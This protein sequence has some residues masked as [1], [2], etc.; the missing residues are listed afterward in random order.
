[1]PDARC[2]TT[3]RC[4][5]PVAPFIHCIGLRQRTFNYHN[6]IDIRMLTTKHTYLYRGLGALGAGLVLIGIFL[7][8]AS[9]TAGKIGPFG[10]GT[11]PSG[12]DL[13]YKQQLSGSTLNIGGAIFA[14]VFGMVIFAVIALVAYG[15]GRDCTSFCYFLISSSVFFLI[16]M[17]ALLPFAQQ[18]IPVP[19]DPFTPEKQAELA[20]LNAT[21][22]AEGSKQYSQMMTLEAQ[23]ETV[24]QWKNLKMVPHAGFILSFS[25]SAL[26]YI[27][28]RLVNSDNIRLE[29]WRKYQAILSQ[30]HADGKVTTDEAAILAKERQLLKISQPDHEYIIRKTVAD[31]A[32]QQRLLAM[33][34]APIDVEQVLRRRE[35]DTYK[36]SLVQA[37]ADGKVTQDESD[38]LRT[39]REGLG[40]TEADHEAMMSE[41]IESGEIVLAGPAPRANEKAE[42]GTDSAGGPS[43][44]APPVPPSV[45]PPELSAIPPPEPASNAASVPGGTSLPSRPVLYAPPP[46]K[47]PAGDMASAPVSLLGTGLS[48]QPPPAPPAPAASKEPLKLVKCTKCGETIP[49]FTEE[50]PLE[51]VCPRCGFKGMLRK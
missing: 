17:L 13:A 49:V 48:S 5:L 31:P 28:A 25:G 40:I 37:H 15:L 4:L 46:G 12:W 22:P 8:W 16:F 3:A 38:L 35:F 34:A 23:R 1:M 27:G 26:A 9:I 47:P 7:P 10:E 21:D 45:P 36:R 33:H 42:G 14:A 11:T 24:L 51:L 30:V 6:T 32:T 20:A 44:P 19:D 2:P 50:R 43:V 18:A 39:Q 29:N 41:L